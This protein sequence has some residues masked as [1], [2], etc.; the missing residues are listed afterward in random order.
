MS[1][2]L[3]LFLPHADADYRWLR[4]AGDDVVARGE[5]LPDPGDDTTV[6]IAPAGA[7]TLHWAELPDR[8]PAQATAAARV[9]TA[10]ASAAPIAELHVAVGREDGAD[11]PIGV[12]AAADMRGWL[13]ALAAGGVDPQA[14]LPAPMLLPRPDSGFVRADLGGE[15]VVRGATSGF[16][17]EARLTDLVT[18]GEAPTVL[19]RGAIEAAIAAA[20]ARPALD[21]RQGPFARRRRRALD[22]ALIRRLAVLAG[23]IL[24][25]TLAIS[26]VRIVRYDLAAGAAEDRADALARSGLPRGESVND[27]A[28]QLDARLLGLRGPGQGFSR[29]V[30]AVFAAVQG[31]PGSEVTR[32]D[33]A[34]TGE[35]HVGL[36]CENEGEVT[37]LLGRLQAS[38]F[39]ARA[40]VFT[41]A[42]GRVSGELTVTP[43]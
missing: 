18:G 6:A 37:D 36:A 39:A 1:D 29:T 26:L 33:F 41:S 5:G 14:I 12:V 38:G 21:L 9:L 32:V 40:G 20:V 34:E 24:L 35:L 22:W 31:V 10:E 42:G 25:V 13:Q 3:V 23:V 17:D 11:R 16:A 19:D 4:V 27:A 43:R 30:A 2:T 28:R 8:S 7:V 15:G